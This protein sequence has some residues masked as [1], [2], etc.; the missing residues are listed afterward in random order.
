MYSTGGLK[1]LKL[2]EKKTVGQHIFTVINYLILTLLMLAC[3][4]PIWYVFI[5]SI[6]DPSLV[7]TG[8]SFLPKG[9]TLFNYK[10]I[11]EVEGIGHAT[12]VSVARTVIGTSVTLLSCTFLG[13]VFTKKEMPARQFFYRA[14]VI[15][16]YVSGGL[17]PYYLLIKA[18]G[19]IPSFL[20]YI[21][22]TA[23]SAFYVIL[24]KTFIEQLPAALEEAAMID[25]AGY[26]I[27]FVR[28][29]IPLSLPIIATIA[30]FSAVN[31]WNSWFDNYMFNGNT[32]KLRTLQLMLY[33]VLNESERLARQIRQQSSSIGSTQNMV[34]KMKF[35]PQ[36]IRMT[37][38]MVVTIPILLV[39]PFMQRFFV[40]GI[41]IG[42]VKG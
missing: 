18:Y 15:T 24:I 22:P 36:G 2:K 14:L 40:K 10:K 6:S 25:G 33:K 12:L 13:Y 28:I 27:I 23:V 29:I 35:S 8:I 37:V 16:M 5:Y 21:L 32:E 17:I 41:M 19:M 7:K 30:V 39:Y 26:I 20:V 34:Q 38:T 3:I 4:Y 42:A 9:I 31:H 11:F 1:K